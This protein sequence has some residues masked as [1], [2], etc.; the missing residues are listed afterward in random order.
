MINDISAKFAMPNLTP[1]QYFNS[2]FSHLP[3]DKLFPYSPSS[4]PVRP[5]PARPSQS[6]PPPALGLPLSL[7]RFFN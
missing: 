5:R 4:P 1:Q 2:L 7:C 6:S 3:S